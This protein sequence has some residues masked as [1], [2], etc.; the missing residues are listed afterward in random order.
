MPLDPKEFEA[1]LE[2]LPS[3]DEFGDCRVTILIRGDYYDVIISKDINIVDKLKT[4]NF[5]EVADILIKYRPLSVNIF[6]EFI[7]GYQKQVARVSQD[8]GMTDEG[9][10]GVTWARD[11]VDDDGTRYQHG[12]LAQKI[13]DLLTFN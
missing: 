12:M 10:Y 4:T 3:E 8:D 5:Q 7:T 6:R 1:E 13:S 11:A 2:D 9:E